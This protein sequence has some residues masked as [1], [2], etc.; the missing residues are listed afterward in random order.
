LNG[1]VVEPMNPDVCSC[2]HLKEEHGG[3]MTGFFKSL[4]GTGALVAKLAQER[5]TNPNMP[6]PKKVYACLLCG[7]KQF[8]GGV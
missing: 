7:C 3:K 2:L 4:P 1:D 6:R 5:L 8:E